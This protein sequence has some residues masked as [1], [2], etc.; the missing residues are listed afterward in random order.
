MK[1]L[2]AKQPSYFLHVFRSAKMAKN[3]INRDK[4]RYSIHD[5]ILLLE[6]NF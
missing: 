4:K 6:N 3:C 2:E 1:G 5:M